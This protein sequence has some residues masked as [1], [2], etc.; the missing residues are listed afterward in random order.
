MTKDREWVVGIFAHNE[1]RGIVHCLESLKPEAQKRP[2][3][4]HV[5]ANGCT[6]NTEAVVRAYAQSHPGVHLARIALGDKANAWNHFVHAIGPRCELVFFMD[7]DVEALPEALGALARQLEADAHANAISALPATGRSGRS[8]TGSEV[9]ERGVWGG[10]YCLRGTFVAQLQER[11]LRLPVGLIGDDGLVGAFVKWDL[12]PRQPWDETRVA[13]NTDPNARF[14]FS[15]LSP[16][17]PAHVR[18]YLR[19]MVRYSIRGFQNRMLTRL[20]KEKGFTGLPDHVVELYRRYPDLCRLRF[21]GTN[22]LFD[23]L[24]LRRM[25]AQLKAVF[26]TS[27]D[28]PAANP[29]EPMNS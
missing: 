24:A 4:I 20:L 9:A 1:E 13:R 17:N 12:D 14:R 2:L 3:T 16:L 7:G 22:T 11:H 21:R 18:L 5:L 26:Q 25:H 6:D 29:R 27:Q 28:Q 23:W 15:P 8:A 19:R 10:L